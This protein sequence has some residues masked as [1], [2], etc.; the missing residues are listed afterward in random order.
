MDVI[1][2]CDRLYSKHF[3][4]ILTKQIATCAVV[5]LFV[6]AEEASLNFKHAAVSHTT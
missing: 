2:E 1:G 4:H 3:A 5:S 6:P